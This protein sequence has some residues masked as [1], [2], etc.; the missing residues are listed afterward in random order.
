VRDFERQTLNVQNYEV[1][2]KE[3]NDQSSSLEREVEEYREELDKMNEICEKMF[4]ENQQLKTK[5]KALA[6]ETKENCS[7]DFQGTILKLGKQL[8]AS[9][10]ANQ[11]L[12]RSLREKTQEADKWQKLT[13]QLEKLQATQPSASSKPSTVPPFSQ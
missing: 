1:Q 11:G 13:A 5:I 12:E 6:Q 10:A 8:E 7:K 2:I 3:L 9:A 4:S